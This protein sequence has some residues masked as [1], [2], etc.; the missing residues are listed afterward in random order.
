MQGGI[1]KFDKSRKWCIELA[2]ENEHVDSE[3]RCSRGWDQDDR[4]PK[5]N[6]GREFDGKRCKEA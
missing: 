1:I 6:G 5:Q 3:G 2:I 4:K